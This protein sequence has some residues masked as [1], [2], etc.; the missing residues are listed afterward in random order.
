VQRLARWLLICADRA[1]CET[2]KMSQ[3]FLSEM[4]GSTRSTVSITAAQL[5]HERL[6]DYTRGVIRI[7]NTPGLERRACECYH[8]IKDHLDNYAEFDTGIAV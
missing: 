6:I 4:L 7:L 3:E 5:K 1:H 8:V 2:F